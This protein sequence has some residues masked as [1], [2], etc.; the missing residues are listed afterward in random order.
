MDPLIKRVLWGFLIVSILAAVIIIYMVLAG[1][2]K[3]PA[4]YD[5]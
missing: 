2:G 4:V 3:A 1:Q 5:F